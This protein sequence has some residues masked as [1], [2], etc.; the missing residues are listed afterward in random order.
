M[1]RRHGHSGRGQGHG[2]HRRIRDKPI[3]AMMYHISRHHFNHIHAEL[4]EYDVYPGQPPLMF[5]LA[6]QNGQSQ[7]ELAEQLEITPATLTVMIKRMEK[8]GLLRREADVEDQRISRI[9]LTDKGLEI[10]EDVRETLERLEQQAIEGLTDEDIQTLRQ[11]LLRINRNISRSR[12]TSR[13]E[14]EA[15]AEENMEASAEA[16]TEA[17][18]DSNEADED[19]KDEASNNDDEVQDD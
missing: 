15:G 4:S 17:S 9:Y 7:K 6:R 2:G 16:N 12:G 3:M 18:E 13:S 14:A 10:L 19:M 8:N 5:A 11:L 1:M